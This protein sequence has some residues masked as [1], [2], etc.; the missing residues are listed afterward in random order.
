LRIEDVPL[1]GGK[2]ASLGE[3]YRELTAQGVRVPN[4]FATTADAFR[5]TLTKAAAWEELHKLVDDLDKRDLRR[6]AEIGARAREIV[7]A[8]GLTTEV[9][10]EVRAAY[11]QLEAEYGAGLSVAVPSSATAEDLPTASFAGQHD[12]FLNV[13]GEAM[14]LDAIRRCNASLFTDRAISYRLDQGFGHFKVALS[15]GVMKMVRADLATSG[16]MFSLDTE[17][18]FRDVVFI[19]GAYG[20]GENVVKGTVD[21]GRVLCSQADR[22]AGLSRRSAARPGPEP[23]QDGLRPRPHP[24]GG[25]EPADAEG[26]PSEILHRR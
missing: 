17:T 1:V 3:M 9:Q 4:G 23:G 18:G 13:R 19:T 21:P 26:R 6:L 22:P 15:V 24:R 12:T 11:R 5:E 2:K 10:Q 25:G 7:Y 20:L 8:A 14:L 16:V